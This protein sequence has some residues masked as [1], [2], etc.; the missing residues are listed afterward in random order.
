MTLPAGRFSLR[1]KNMRARNSRFLPFGLALRCLA[2]LL[3]TSIAVGAIAAGGVGATEPTATTTKSTSVSGTSSSK[4]RTHSA[5]HSTVRRRHRGTPAERRARTA[6]LKQ[7]FVASTELRPMAQQLMTMRTAAAYAGVTSYAQRHTGDAAAAAYL[8]LG[9]AYQIDKRDQDA[10]AALKQVKLHSEELA[11]YADY[12]AAECEHEAGH[13]AAAEALLK[14]FN[15]RHPDSIFDVEAP[16]LEANVLL[17][18]GDAT[19]AQRVLLTIA[20]VAHDMPNYELTSA[21]IAFAIQQNAE[22]ERWFKH[23]L[24]SHPLSP[25]A[26]TARARLTAM[27]AESSLTPTELRSLGDAYYNAGRY[28]LAA[29][30]YHALARNATLDANMRNGFAVAAAACDLKLK[31]LTDGEARAIAGANGANGVRRL[32][33]VQ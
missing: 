29:E 17:A 15:E 24:L 28:N 22:A 27:G 31:R 12:L 21:K 26:E 32:C 19:A 11:D 33:L 2:G 10:T 18:Q 7:A 9:R 13:E 8:S 30:Q 25:E 1:G 6:R 23:L 3:C 4:K 14:G 16:E 5:T 20:D